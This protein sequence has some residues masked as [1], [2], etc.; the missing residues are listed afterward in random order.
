MW[1]DRHQP[2]AALELLIVHPQARID[3]KAW[4]QESERVLILPIKQIV[5][6]AER[7]QG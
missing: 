6:P 4:A 7:G 1:R 3:R 2:L 5:G